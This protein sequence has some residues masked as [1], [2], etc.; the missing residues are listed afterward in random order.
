[1]WV[2][3]NGSVAIK[4]GIELVV[5]GK[6]DFF[7][8]LHLGSVDAIGIYSSGNIPDT[9][10]SVEAL[11]SSWPS[12]EGVEKSLSWADLVEAEQEQPTKDP[13]EGVPLIEPKLEPD[14]GH[15]KESERQLTAVSPATEARVYTQVVSRTVPVPIIIEAVSSD[16]PALGYLKSGGGT[17]PYPCFVK[18][19]KETTPV[20]YKRVRAG[21]LYRRLNE[22]GSTDVEMD[23]NRID[24]S[25][26]SGASK[27]LNR[28]FS[29][30]T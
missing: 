22:D 20:P 8:L 10:D 6:E 26:G 29:L 30:F 7:S 11:Y 13:P 27:R 17:L 23:P 24:I 12:L 21:R 9:F 19:G 28:T 3:P 5:V 1:M 25:A 2:M 18:D 16:H 4:D 14:T 15:S